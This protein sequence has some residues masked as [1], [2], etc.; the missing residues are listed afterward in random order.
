[1]TASSSALDMPGREQQIRL[2]SNLTQ[3][4]SSVP[5]SAYIYGLPATGKTTL[6]KHIFSRQ[7][8]RLAFVDVVSVFTQTL[9]FDAILSCLAP[10]KLR[11]ELPKCDSVSQFAAALAS[12]LAHDPAPRFIVLDNAEWLRALGTNT[13]LVAG[14]LRISEMSKTNVCVILISN[15]EWIR[16]KESVECNDPALFVYFPAYTR[17]ETRAILALDCPDDEKEDPQFFMQF[18]DLAMQVLQKPCRDLNELRHLVALLFVKYREPVLTGKLARN[19]TAK[20]YS[21]AQSYFKEVIDKLYIRK[22]SSSEWA[23]SSTSS[24]RV[25]TQQLSALDTLDM[26]LPYNTLYLLLASFIASYNPKGL[27][28]RF[29][30]RAGE[31]RKGKKSG[32]EKKT[33][34]A[35]LR[36]QLLGPKPFPLE[37]MLAIF[38]RIKEDAHPDVELESLV[39]IQ[40]QVTGLISRGLLLRMSAPG[41]IEE[42][43]LKCNVGMEVAF[44][45]AG[46]MRFELVRYFLIVVCGS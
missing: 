41:R 36:Q 2:L 25:A 23:N 27:D 1:M 38:Y 16:F 39:D 46:R 4:T 24:A 44:G 21:Y 28:V 9:L 37:R 40:M 33:T 35:K 10:I 12:L 7:Q 34:S 43:R 5:T 17:A 13:M 29:F 3:M 42:V 6:A 26:D 32:R 30:A 14:L 31:K 8:H 45:V 20:L 18:V 19:E 11:E 22:I 15:L